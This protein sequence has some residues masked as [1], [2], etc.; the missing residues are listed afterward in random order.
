MTIGIYRPSISTFFLRNS[1]ASGIADIVVTYGLPGDSPVVGDWD[2]NGTTT[3]GIYRS[4][5]SLFSLRNANSAGDADA[6][7]AFG[8]MGDIPV[9]GNWY[10]K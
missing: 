3:V 4:S 8:L 5:L 6:T 10:G 2:G 9:V 1:N 7:V